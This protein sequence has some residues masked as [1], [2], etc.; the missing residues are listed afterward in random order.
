MERHSKMGVNTDNPDLKYK[1][2]IIDLILESWR[3]SR[4]FNNMLAKLSDYKEYTRYQGRYLYFRKKLDEILD[5][6]GLRI[7]EI[8]PGTDYDIGMAAI[9]INLEDFDS[10]DGLKIEQMLE[11]IIMQD[12]SVIKIGK[13]ILKKI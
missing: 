7:V 12:S 2:L 11:P 6:A 1:D 10:D 13:I 5:S 3:F 4:V 9:P 8:P